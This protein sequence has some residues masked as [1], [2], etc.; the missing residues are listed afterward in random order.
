MARWAKDRDA[1]APAALPMNYEQAF[2]P[3]AIRSLMNEDIFSQPTGQRIRTWHWL[4][5]YLRYAMEELE[6]I[7][8][9]DAE[10]LQFRHNRA[11]RRIMAR[12]MW[13]TYVRRIPGR[14]IIG[15]KPRRL[16][17]TTFVAGLQH[18]ITR[19]TPH[20]QSVVLAH[21]AKAS[22]TIF[23]WHKTFSSYINARCKSDALKDPNLSDR[24]KANAWKNHPFFLPTAKDNEGIIQWRDFLGDDLGFVEEGGS[25]IRVFTAGNVKGAVGNASGFIHDAEIGVDDVDWD[26]VSLANDRMVPSLRKDGSPAVGTFIFKEGATYLDDTGG[27]MAAT[28]VYLQRQIEAIHNGES[29]YT[30]IFIPWYDVDR[31][32]LPLKPGET[33]KPFGSGIDSNRK[34]AE[35]LEDLRAAMAR[36]WHLERAKTP[37]ARDAILDEIEEAL[38]YRQKILLPELSGDKDALHSQYPAQW[39]EAFVSRAQR[40]FSGVEINDRIEK[41]VGK[42]PDY[43]SAR[44]VSDRLVVYRD[45]MPGVRYTIPSDHSSGTA[46]DGFASW[47]QNSRDLGIDAVL[48]SHDAST[49]EQAGE[50]AELAHMYALKQKDDGGDFCMVQPA[51]LIPEANTFGGEVMRIL[52]DELGFRHVWRRR[53][54]DPKAG[55]QQRGELGFWTSEDKRWDAIGFLQDQWQTWGIW[56]QRI[57]RQMANFG[58]R[59]GKQKPVAVV[60]NDDFV[61]CGWIQA[62]V[63]RVLGYV[64][65][66]DWRSY[67]V[68]DVRE[69]ISEEGN[70]LVDRLH[71]ECD[72]AR[73]DVN[74]GIEGAKTRLARLE[75]KLKEASALVAADMAAKEPNRAWARM[76]RG[77]FDGRTGDHR[78]RGIGGR[79]YRR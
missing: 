25:S 41:V 65:G 14:Y 5:R 44:I 21:N 4:T 58:Y 52:W 56:D 1:G 37:E 29:S 70:N 75:A 69:L 53:P 38:N 57:L 22:D 34:D 19:Y 77:E 59:K 23:G 47:V 67:M 8:T 72:I 32:R 42:D 50:L 48:S 49:K 30:H 68:K 11:Q 13:D 54:I 3:S 76:N 31:Y 6:Y 18:I 27:N 51:L 79:R 24:D 66:P 45:P 35:E 15:P 39:K 20:F 28:G 26:F 71:A 46:E 17:A 36:D 33:V 16:G 60:G 55:E 61:T 62:Y 63:N 12:V 2:L 7:V 78:M 10:L 74:R 43:P 64:R 40:I 9:Q 73:R